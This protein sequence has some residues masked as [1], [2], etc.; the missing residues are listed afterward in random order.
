MVRRNVR[1]C[2][3][4]RR[5]SPS[6]SRELRFRRLNCRFTFETLRDTENFDGKTIGNFHCQEQNELGRVGCLRLRTTYM[7]IIV[8]YIRIRISPSMLI[9][10][11]LSY[12]FSHALPLCELLPFSTLLNT[13]KKKKKKNVR[14]FCTVVCL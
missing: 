2:G 10:A 7:K 6:G 12:D 14:L 11:A 1:F 4:N 13:R 9:D 3:G 8:K 5:T